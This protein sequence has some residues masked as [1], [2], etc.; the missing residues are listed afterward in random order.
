M[1]I[2]KTANILSDST[3][4]EPTYFLLVCDWFARKILSSHW[5]KPIRQI[6]SPMWNRDP[7]FIIRIR[8]ERSINPTPV[9]CPTPPHRSPKSMLKHNFLFPSSS[10]WNAV[11]RGHFE[12]SR[13]DLQK[14]MCGSP[15]PS[16]VGLRKTFIFI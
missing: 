11:L 10:Y 13:A 1:L 3:C 8:L 9:G 5:L 15:F 4:D 7:T 6:S 2:A 12:C 14:R 16:G